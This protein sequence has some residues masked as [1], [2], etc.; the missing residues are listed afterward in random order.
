[1][2]IN[3]PLPSRVNISDVVSKLDGIKDIQTLAVFNAQKESLI[4]AV[5]DLKTH[6]T[7]Q[8]TQ[9]HTLASSLNENQT[10]VTNLQSQNDSL[11]QQNAANQAK[12]DELNKKLAAATAAP[13]PADPAALA[14]SFKNV[15][16][17]IQTQARV[18]SVSGP[19]TTLRSM[20]IEVKGL[21]NVQDGSTVL[22][23]PTLGSPIDPN[24]LSTL[25]LSFAAIPGAGRPSPPSLASVSPN[26][27][28]P[29]GGTT[30]TIM[31]SSFTGASA[32]Q[33]GS[34]PASTF[35]VA[36]DT[37]MTAVSPPGSG[38]VDVTVTTPAGT[39]AASPADQ[40]TY[41]APPSVAAVKPNQGPAG[42]GTKVVVAGAGFTGATAVRFGSTAAASFVVT[43][44]TTIQAVSPAGS[45]TVDVT[46][47]TAGG[48]SATGT[49]DQFTYLSPP[50]VTAIEPNRGPT[51]GG[52][53]VT[54]AGSG[55]VGARA[56]QFGST[57]VTG[58][59]VASD[60]QITA[61]SP[62]GTGQV[63]VLVTTANGT[64]AATDKDVFTYVPVIP[65]PATRTRKGR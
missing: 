16:D 25:R 46:V 15:I 51:G 14:A 24:Q 61:A 47:T 26:S 36:S 30:V 37:Q 55:F 64:S 17:H 52:T 4:Q 32:I 35:S 5:Q 6:L 60:T 21:V 33:F 58:F 18:Q 62:A 40:F 29:A 19:A 7:D 10:A 13:P 28:P 11:K 48:T 23:M 57:A 20:D 3:P 50:A 41:V 42:G 38:T 12:I 56:V 8:D 49:P 65:R 27:G 54:I 1:M 53:K 59:S 43:N 39:S 31:G 45:G 9:I 63:H 44:D 22:V 2:P 34:I